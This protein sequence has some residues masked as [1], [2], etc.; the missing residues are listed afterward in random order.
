MVSRELDAAIGAR[1]RLARECAGESQVSLGRLLGFAQPSYAYRC[2]KG[3]RGFTVRQLVTIAARYRVS[4]DWLLTG[5]EFE[6]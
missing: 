3:L 5:K 2:E 4:V 1:V 6:P